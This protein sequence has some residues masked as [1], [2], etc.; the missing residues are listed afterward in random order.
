M[1]EDYRGNFSKRCCRNESPIKSLLGDTI[2]IKKELQDA[3]LAMFCGSNKAVFYSLHRIA[4][5]LVLVL[6]GIE[7]PTTYG[8]S[9]QIIML[10]AVRVNREGDSSNNE[11]ENVLLA[12]RYCLI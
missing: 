9:Q 5:V 8:M 10:V 6:D 11:V 2:R 12:Q 3:D 1:K 4:A 7:Q